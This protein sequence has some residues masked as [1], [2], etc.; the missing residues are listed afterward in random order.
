M[1]ELTKAFKA[2]SDSNR[3]RIFILLSR[4]TLCVNSLVHCLDVSQPAVSQHLRI[5]REA[6]LVNVE[7]RGYWMHYSAK[8]EKVEQFIK[9]FNNLLGGERNVQKDKEKRV[10]TSRK[11]KGKAGRM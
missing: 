7:K 4:R 8:K 6:D 11:I 5:L 2:L 9:K 3:L 1:Q 10:R